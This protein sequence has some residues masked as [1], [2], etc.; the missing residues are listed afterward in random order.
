MKTGK[1]KYISIHALCE[2][3]DVE[4]AKNLGIY[5]EF[6][7]TP[8]ARRATGAARPFQTPKKKFLS[9]PSARRATCGCAPVVVGD[10]I[11]IH[12]LCEEGDGIGFF[13]ADGGI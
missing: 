11:S 3:G 4:W 8:S 7:S 12:A 5:K 10:L 2:E 9:T 1:F 13:E 6:L